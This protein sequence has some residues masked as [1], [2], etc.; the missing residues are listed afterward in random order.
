M[1]TG[2]ACNRD[3]VGVDGEASAH[4]AARLMRERHVGDLVITQWRGEHRVPVG[5]VTDRDLVIE[6]IAAELDIDAV[7]IGD[8]FSFPSLVTASVEDELEDT[9]AA[10][11]EHGIRRVPVVEADGRLAGIIAMDDILGVIADDLVRLAA[12]SRRQPDIEAR[13]RA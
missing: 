7:T 11:S 4:E 9:L 2:K 5:I 13:R 8:L 3:V 1:K 12:L 6:V 10:M